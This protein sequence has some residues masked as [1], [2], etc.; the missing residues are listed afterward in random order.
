MMDKQDLILQGIEKLGTELQRQGDLIH[1]LITT[2]G[3]MGKAV[4]SLE[5]RVERLEQKVDSLGKR[6]DGVAVE[7]S[8]FRR[9]TKSNFRRLEGHMRLV[10]NDLDSAIERIELLEAHG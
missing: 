8:A 10:D 2:V 5:Q 3:A 7:L 1:Q 4:N 9:D 6:L